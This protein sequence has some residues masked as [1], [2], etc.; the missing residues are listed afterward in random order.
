MSE[1]RVVPTDEFLVWE[2]DQE[3]YLVEKGEGGG[4][5]EETLGSYFVT[6]SS[7]FLIPRTTDK[8]SNVKP[9]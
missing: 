7:D 3:G 5:I 2:I 1:V 8:P 6:T 9:N 4:T